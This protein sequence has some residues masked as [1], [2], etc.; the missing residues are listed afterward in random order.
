MTPMNHLSGNPLVSIITICRNAMPYIRDCIDSVLAQDYARVEVIVQDGASTDGTFEVLRSFGDRI[1]LVSMPD[2][3]HGE[4]MNRALQRCTGDIIGTCNADDLLLPHA[5]TW[6]VDHFARSLA[7]AVYGDYFEINE[8]GSIQSGP[9]SGPAAFDLARVMCVEDVIPMQSAFFRRSALSRAGLLSDPW[10]P[11]LCEDYLFWLNLGMVTSVDRCP[12]AISHY[13]VHAGSGTYQPGLWDRIFAAK[14]EVLERFL[15]RSDV[16]FALRSLRSRAL[17]GIALSV[18]GMFLQHFDDI[19]TGLDYI[20]IAREEQPDEKH[21]RHLFQTIRL[22]MVP[23]GNYL[24]GATEAFLSG[25]RDV[26]IER[27]HHLRAV[28]WCLPQINDTLKALEPESASADVGTKPGDIGGSG[29]GQ[30]FPQPNGSMA[31]GSAR[32]FEWSTSRPLVDII[33]PGPPGTPFSW[34]QREGWV[35]ALIR[36]GMLNRVYWVWDNAHVIRRMM[37]DLSQ[38]EA[39]FIFAM[40]CDH[41]MPYL[42]DSPEKVEFWRSLHLP[43]VCHCAE[44]IVGSPF[45]DSEQKTTAA[46]NVFDAFVYVD[47]LSESLFQAVGKPSLWV[48]QYVDEMLYRGGA[49]EGRTNKV[50]FR[51]Q[52]ANFGVSG[53]YAARARLLSYVRD[54][55]LFELSEAYKPLLT[56]HQA[57]KLKASYRFVLNP[58][59]NCS[60]YSSSLYEAMAGGCAVF[61]YILPPA[62]VHSRRLFQPG[63]HFISYDEGN[64]AALAAQAAEACHNWQDYARVAREGMEEC[65]SKHTIHRRLSEIIEFVTCNWQQVRRTPSASSVGLVQ[66]ARL[67][68]VE[69]GTRSTRTASDATAPPP[70]LPVHFFTIVLNGEPFIRHHINIFRRLPFKWHWHIVEGVA[71]LVHDTGWCRSRG[72]RITKDL[73][74]CGLSADGTTAYLDQLARENPEVTIYRKAE[75]RFWDGKLEMV[76]APLSALKEECL[77]WQVDADEYWTAEQIATAREM[78]LSTP[79]KTASYYYCRFFVGTD[80]IVTTRGTY[81]NRTQYEWLRTWRYRPG[82]RWLSH[83]P[84]SLCRRNARGELIDLARINPFRHAETEARHLIFDHHAYVSEAQIRFKEVYY[85]YAGALASWKA[86]QSSK[87]FPILLRNFFPWV[88]DETRVERLAPRGGPPAVRPKNRLLWVRT[89]SIGD[90]I[91]AGG[92]LPHIKAAYP[93][94]DITVVCQEHVKSLYEAFPGIAAVIGIDKQRAYRDSAYLTRLAEQ[95]STRNFTLALNPIYSRE[96]ISDFLTLASN[97]RE[98]VGLEGDLCNI[99]REE[100]DRNSAYYTRIVP[101]SATECNELNHQRRFLKAID[102]GSAPIG[103]TIWTTPEDE[104]YADRVF[105]D[106][107]LD[108]DRTI[109]VFPGAQSRL[110][111]YP[112]MGQALRR[113]AGDFHWKVIAFGSASEAGSAQA[114]LQVAGAEAI[115]LCGRTSL[116]QTAA[117]LRRCRLG[118]GTESGPAHMACAVGTSHVVVVGGGHFGRFMPFSPLTSLVCLPLD[119][120]GCNWKCRNR[121]PFCIR[122]IHPAVLE[123]AILQSYQVSASVPRLFIQAAGPWL[124]RMEESRWSRKPCDSIDAVQIQVGMDGPETPDGPLTPV[125]RPWVEKFPTGPFSLHHMAG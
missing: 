3:G 20:R 21:L 48:P 8:Q 42:H 7:G 22:W 90:A 4:A 94:S 31:T 95:I 28:D 47:E 33:L 81:G 40:S 125:S 64:P 32:R 9:H 105:A 103:S 55:P 110:R 109:G 61:Q 112:W 70:E 26:A 85:G 98:R 11:K 18:A 88:S 102:A 83:E 117:L 35:H 50:F 68:A 24:I 93:G 58:P 2:S 78:F 76:N 13:R 57:A 123:Q 74:A 118:V 43:V 106:S 87:R 16:P 82:D 60:G 69:P 23:I 5:A 96:P 67:D 77:L 1:R 15:I 100:R 75:G 99:A 80:L 38:S 41:H 63:R 101:N 89:D 121:V 73:H 107:G 79:E 84:P 86:L 53:A 56:P 119:C 111:V 52:V 71:D 29:P 124:D 36:A 6:A 113:V 51:G 62:E 37:Q 39:D 54:N 46:L 17:G 30:A 115:N 10:L 25:R 65:L 45:P 104:S 34:C 49:F 59:A 97:A 108:P 114:M 19:S 12:G 44:R 72:G 120:Y 14:R 116:R 122:G 66:T 27:L 92:M 91:L